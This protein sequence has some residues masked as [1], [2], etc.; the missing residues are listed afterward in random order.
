MALEGF[1][2]RPSRNL[3]S[4]TQAFQY[5]K[6]YW[7]VVVGATLALIVTAGVTLS[8]GQGLRL[9]ID[10]GFAAGSDL[11]LEQS[12]GIFALLVIVL[13]AGTFARFYL[14]SWLGERVS[15][16]IRKDVFDH[17][18]GLDPAFFD[19]NHASEIQTRVTTDTTLVQTVIGS[20]ASIAARN[21]LMLIGGVALLVVTNPKLS[22]LVVLFAPIV[23]APIV[24]FGRRVRRL[25]RS[26]QDTIADVGTYVG[27]VLRNIKTVQAF[28][29]EQADRVNLSQRVDRAFGVA[30]LRV[31]QRAWLTALVMMLVL[32]SIAA[33]LWVGGQDV[34]T[35][36]T[37]P[38]ELTAFI[39]YAFL[40]A[41]SVGALSEV[42]GELQRA[43]GAIERLLE[44]RDA[45]PRIV[46][47]TNPQRL[48]VPVTGALVL[49]GVKFSY[50]SRPDIVVLRGVDLSIATGETVA[51]VGPSGAGKSTLFDLILR[52]YDPDAGTI[53]LDGVDLRRLDPVE[54]RANVALVRQEPALFTGNI[55]E[56]IRYGRPGA[57]MAEVTEAAEAAHIAEF[58]AALPRGLE[59]DLGESG[60]QLSGGQ[61]QRITLARAILKDPPLLLLDEATS[62]LDAESERIVQEAVAKLARDRTT[63]IVAHRLAT[64]VNADRIVVLDGGEVIDSGTH[65]E[66]VGRNPL[67]ARYVELQFRQ[68]SDEERVVRSAT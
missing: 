63:L 3:K 21:L 54:L 32:A 8:I 1:D 36:R 22:G 12:I 58:A 61:R 29:H 24:I 16:D 27:E 60:T 9:L 15:A 42:V 49:E 39:F 40:V 57:S 50:P 44:L 34:L 20:S 28:N 18:V 47:P 14:V 46:A 7:P 6:P 67:Y 4:L 43:A 26:S 37:T 48:P 25:S 41:G 53:S 17:I 13:T 62:S 65:A 68:P 30:K 10:R 23:V 31:R 19:V 2:R 51:I 5:V 66:L 56:N 33:M 45:E 52:F 11:I 38:G 64:V 59:T 55:L 35:G